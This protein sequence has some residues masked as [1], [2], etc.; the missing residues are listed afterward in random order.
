MKKIFLAFMAAVMMF[1]AFAQTQN[2]RTMRVFHNGNIVYQRD[3]LQVDSINFFVSNGN[4]G[5]NGNGNN[6][7]N[8]DNTAVNDSNQIYIGVVAFNRFVNQLPITPNLESVK[9]FIT[10]Q[11]NDQ[12]HTAFAYS[13]SKGNLMFDATGLPEFDKIFMLNFSD[14]TDNYSNSLWGSEGRRV[15]TANV[16][17]TVQFDL[18]KR[19]DLNSYAIGFGDDVGFGEKMRKVVMGSGE[20]HNAKTSADLIPTFNEIAQSILASAKNVV[21][22]TNDG[23]YGEGEKLFR[24]TF[25]AEGG[26][27]DTIY[28]QMVGDPTSGYTLSII[29]EGKYARFDAPV[30]GEHDKNLAKVLLPL[31]NLKFINGEDELRYNFNVEISF[32]GK[33]YYEEVEEASTAE[34][35]SK[36]IAV[37]LVLDCSK[38][39]DDAF[40][41]MKSAAIDFIETLEKMDP[42]A[43]GTLLIDMQETVGTISFNMKAVEGGTFVMG[44][45]SSVSNL[46]NYYSGAEA[47]ESPIH[48]VTLSS[49]LMGETEVTQGLWEYVMGSHNESDYPADV[50]TKYLDPA[51]DYYGNLVVTG[52]SYVYDRYNGSYPSSSYGN[53][54]NYPVYNVSYEDIVGEHGFLDRLNA[55]TGKNYRLPTEAE[56]EYAA[57]GGQQNQYTRET[58]DANSAPSNATQYRYSGGTSLTNVGWY[59][60]NS[61]DTS[62]EVKTKLANEL[63]LYDMSGNVAEYCSDYYNDYTNEAQTNPESNTWSASRVIRGG[64]YSSSISGCRVSNRN[65]I[66]P[67]TSY[68]DLG[69]RLVL[70]P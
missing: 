70:I 1:P 65:N 34:A 2:T 23:Y 33:L 8:G 36:R 18:S 3:A 67:S 7:N 37:V 13:V 58:I 53:G 43:G 66:N 14:G 5:N 29:Q 69:F 17:D 15:A 39:M 46:P 12:D 47:D 25:E 27:L 59:T 26:L 44:A 41:P 31:N 38:S 10:T 54:D 35:V 48:N 6:G 11:S 42:N 51:F 21:L 28:A 52:G 56:W 20:Y 24:F 61:N 57:R 19:I 68:R 60:S 64:S 22:K 49:F 9:S 45:Q 50:S 55:L 40:S 62:H 63:G 30:I 4:T 32:D 16:Y